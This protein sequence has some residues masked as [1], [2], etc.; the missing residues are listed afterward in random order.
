MNNLFK[1]TLKVAFVVLGLGGLAQ[2]AM[3]EGNAAEGEK[4]AA[5]CS[6]CHGSDGNSPSPMFPK[7]AGLGE[8]YLVDQL[9]AIRNANGANPKAA[10]RSIPEMTG[11]L[12]KMSDQDLAN[13]AAFFDSKPMQLSGAKKAEV[14][15]NSGQ[16]VDAL[17]LGEQIYRAGNLE[18]AVPACSGCHSPTGKGNE[19]AGF[20]RLG[21][22]HADYIAKQLRDFRAGNRTTDG[23][24]QI[25]RG[26]AKHLSDAELEAVANYISGLH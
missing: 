10:S 6:A 8:K 5:S 19:P 15:L 12:D 20:P 22:Q 24:A 7:L 26:V 3:A 21:G 1:D 23:D 2:G 11:L 14:Q 9:K 17:K 4:L 13:L 18:T 16:K 25:M